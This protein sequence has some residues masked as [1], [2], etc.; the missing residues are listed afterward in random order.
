M[1]EQEEL[2]KMTWFFLHFVVKVLM[3]SKKIRKVF[4]SK[5]VFLKTVFRQRIAAYAVCDLFHFY[6]ENRVKIF[7][8]R[9]IINNI[10]LKPHYSIVIFQQTVEDR[11]LSTV[12]GATFSIVDIPAIF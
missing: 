8:V 12:G 4:Q 11:P 6:L 10:H 3:L 2:Y 7:H 1:T 9:T 5:L